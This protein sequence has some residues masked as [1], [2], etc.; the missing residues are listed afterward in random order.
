MTERDEPRKR[1][2]G[3]IR[4]STET[5]AEK[6]AGLLAQRARIDE[7][8]EWRRWDILRVAED[9]GISGGT[10]RRPGLVAA[11]D[12][13]DA[14]EAEAL[15]VAKLDRL[16]RSLTDFVSI[17]AR[18]QAGK[19]ALVVLDVDVDMTTPSGELMATMSAA[20]AQYERRIIGQRT[21]DALAIKKAQGVVLGRP[22]R[23]EEGLAAWVHDLRREGFT[24]RQIAD[25]ATYAGVPP[26]Q[27]GR[28]WHAGT[29][30][31]IA[32]RIPAAA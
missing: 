30:L 25:A 29:M 8:C 3:Y 7:A 15:V 21:K 24:W 31:R 17:V 6:G 10:M 19:W 28:R 16:S 18:A 2:L 32:R 14:G 22:D 5:Q 1:V 26:L 9:A 23:A 4:V 13:L 12:A 20:F 11:L 27:G